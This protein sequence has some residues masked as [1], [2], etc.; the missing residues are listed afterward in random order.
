MFYIDR[1]TRLPAFDMRKAHVTRLEA[2][3]KVKD[4]IDQASLKSD[5]NSVRLTQAIDSWHLN[6]TEALLP[7]KS[8]AR[9]DGTGYR[10]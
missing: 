10:F 7:R 3:V 8:W 5:E 6:D 2:R 9:D 1:C 4:L